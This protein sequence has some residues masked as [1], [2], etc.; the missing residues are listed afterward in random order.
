M[1]ARLRSK[2]RILGDS[3]VFRTD[4]RSSLREAEK[5]AQTLNYPPE[6]IRTASF[7]VVSL[8][9]ETILNSS[10]SDFRDWAQKPLML[11]LFGVLNAGETFFE[12][13]RA[14]LE[15]KESQPIADLL[16]V[17]FLC[18]ALGFRGLYGTGSDLQL[19][20]WRTSLVDKILRVRGSTLVDLSPNWRPDAEVDMPSAGSALTRRALN[21]ALGAAATVLIFTLVYSYLLKHG[22]SELINIASK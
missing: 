14:T 5:H 8:L 19:K 11:D 13:V 17:F 16:E 20:T 21:A 7:A 1:I 22:A 15:R 12:Y 3:A 9:D 6:E 10:N 4:V 18:L 2:K